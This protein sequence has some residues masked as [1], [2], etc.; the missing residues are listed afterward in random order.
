M[1][2]LF[3]MHENISPTQE[4]RKKR[5]EAQGYGADTE[6]E[7]SLWYYVGYVM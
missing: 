5:G 2:R 4:A 1:S 7:A 6:E 3:A